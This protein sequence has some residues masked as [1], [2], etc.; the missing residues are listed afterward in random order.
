M[1]IHALFQESQAAEWE[2]MY[3]KSEEIS[4]NYPLGQ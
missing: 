1:K 3:L 4:G 2:Y